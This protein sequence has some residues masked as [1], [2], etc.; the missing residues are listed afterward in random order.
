[1]RILTRSAKMSPWKSA[2]HHAQDLSADGVNVSKWTVQRNLRETGFKSVHPTRKPLL[3]QTMKR[4]RLLWARNHQN[5][6]VEQWR[7]V[8]KT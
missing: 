4:K 3:T 5:W 2:S 6:T 1:M 8:K 7:K